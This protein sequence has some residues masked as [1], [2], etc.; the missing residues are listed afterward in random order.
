MGEISST[1]IP[2]TIAVAMTTD[3][4]A[5]AA[6]SSAT[7]SIATV[8]SDVPANLSVRLAEM[9]VAVVVVS[10]LRDQFVLLRLSLVTS[11]S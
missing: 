9:N 6:V 1:L 10:G 7:V 3:P 11:R 5:I 4:T 2:K 8:M